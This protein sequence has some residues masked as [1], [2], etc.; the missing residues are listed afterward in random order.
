MPN[1]EES[2][3]EMPPDLPGL[4]CG[5]CGFPSCETLAREISGGRAREEAC[6]VMRCG[7][8]VVLKIGE[9]EVPMGEFVQEFLKGAVLG[10]ISQ[11]KKVDLKEG[12]VVELRFRVED[13]DLR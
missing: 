3:E 8:Q 4:D 1:L 7:K 13:D 5:E 12:E 10:M 11:L 9:R 6:P 2:Q